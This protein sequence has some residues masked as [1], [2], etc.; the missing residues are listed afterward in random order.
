MLWGPAQA[1]TPNPTGAVNG[2]DY[3]FERMTATRAVNDRF[4]HGR[5][6]LVALVYR[7]LKNDRHE[8]VLVSHGSTGSQRFDPREPLSS[9]NFIDAQM[10][11][12][13]LKRGYT[14][15]LV[16]RRGMSE[17]TGTYTEE[18]AYQA[19]K[20]TLAQARDLG[21]PALDEALATTDAV[22]E[23]V[24]VK[25]LKPHDG[26][27]IAYG[28]SR[29]GFLSLAFAAAH[30]DRVRAVLAVSPGWM[31]VTDAWPADENA[32][33]L[34]WHTSRLQ[35]MGSKFKGP[36]LW[37]CAARD[38]TYADV[39]TRQFFAAY[40]KGGGQ[41]EYVFIAEHNLPSGH[42]PPMALWKD[43]AGQFF[44]KLQ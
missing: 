4:D 33:R 24:V 21:Q 8:V 15:V 34:E 36:T 2:V 17:S 7:P 18:C 1:Q 30:P 42:Q 44:D 10:H 31:S 26:K 11:S 13:L 43:S 28:G 37:I 6:T 12:I 3:T 22:F 9:A 5:I 35:Q 25:R 39:I 38:P 16:E 19:G 20:C 23:Q 40:Q 14:L 29:G 41:G 27:V 32:L